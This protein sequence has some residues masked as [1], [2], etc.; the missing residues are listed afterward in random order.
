MSAPE[1]ARGDLAGAPRHVAGA[2]SPLFSQYAA[3]RGLT[4]EDAHAG[5]L[6]AFRAWVYDLVR[7]EAR[8]SA[9]SGADAWGNPRY[10]AYARAHGRTPRAQLAHDALTWPGGRMTGYILWVDEQ[11]QRFASAYPESMAGDRV[12]DPMQLTAFLERVARAVYEAPPG[13]SLVSYQTAGV[14]PTAPWPV[15]RGE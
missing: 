13:E 4:P 3:A 2:W 1:K 15:R 10:A 7:Q 8:L 9:G 11:K 5:G 12:R 6:A 14:P